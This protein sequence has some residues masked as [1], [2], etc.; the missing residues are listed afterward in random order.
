MAI[1]KNIALLG[2]TSKTR[3]KTT[4][5]IFSYINIGERGGTGISL[6]TAAAKEENYSSP[7]FGTWTSYW[8]EKYR[9][10]ERIAI[11]QK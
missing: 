6:I 11:D 5:D 10:W 1:S 7:T 9:F 4:L 8:Y 2:G 3:N